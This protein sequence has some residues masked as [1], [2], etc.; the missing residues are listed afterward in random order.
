MTTTIDPEAV[1]ALPDLAS[2]ALPPMS[3]SIDAVAPAYVVAWSQLEHVAKNADNPH[4]GSKFASLD[5]VLDVVRPI[6]AA[7]G[8]AIWQR[9]LFAKG[10]VRLQTVIMHGATGQFLADGA[11]FRKSVKDDPQAA[12]SALTYLRR[13]ALACITGV[14]QAD[15]DGAAAAKAPKPATKAVKLAPEKDR[16]ALQKRINALPAAYVQQIRDKLGPEA[17]VTA[18][19]QLTVAQAKIVKGW[20]D[21]CEELAKAEG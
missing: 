20:V 13:Q 17:G 18:W 8:L 16:A 19:T 12:G 7:Q 5:A 10:G 6:L 2:A 4:F 1:A 9:E 3:P 11:P 14:A 15:D 21:E